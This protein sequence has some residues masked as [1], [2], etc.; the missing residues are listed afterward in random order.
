MPSIT[1]FGRFEDGVA[2]GLKLLGLFR[3]LGKR[4]DHLEKPSPAE[5][6]TVFQFIWA[7]N[8]IDRESPSVRGFFT[9][10]LRREGYGAEIMDV[11]GTSDLIDIQ[12]NSAPICNLPAA[13]GIITFGSW[14]G[15][16]GDGDAW[17]LDI[18][19][20]SICCVPVGSPKTREEARLSAYATFYDFHYLEAFLRR[21]A[22]L[23]GWLPAA[24]EREPRTSQ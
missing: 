22:E 21:A 16:L 5:L 15:D 9:T 7:Q 3:D 12:S 24:P 8:I 6:E 14:T 20:G 19:G 4:I 23:R 18:Q 13:S 2:A 10:V 11:Y 17:C 1:Q